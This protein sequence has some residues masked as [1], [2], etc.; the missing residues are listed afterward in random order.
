MKKRNLI[1]I[2]LICILVISA[3]FDILNLLIT[4]HYYEYNMYQSYIKNAAKRQGSI[5]ITGFVNPQKKTSPFARD[6]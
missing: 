3:F 6:V 2:V 5:K 1:V 4:Q